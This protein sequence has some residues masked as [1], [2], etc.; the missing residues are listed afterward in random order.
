MSS[1]KAELQ[2]PL[3]WKDMAV[4]EH[5][6]MLLKN[7]GWKLYTSR[8]NYHIPIAIFWWEVGCKATRRNSSYLV[9]IDADNT[10][11]GAGV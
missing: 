11:T 9:T 4:E 10:V 3:E 2:I 8:K 6:T 5:R 7:L 1:P